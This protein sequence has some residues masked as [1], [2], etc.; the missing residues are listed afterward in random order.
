MRHCWWKEVSFT[1]FYPLWNTSLIFTLRRWILTNTLLSLLF[2]LF[3]IFKT[4]SSN[5]CCK[6]FCNKL[7]EPG[8]DPGFLN[9]GLM[10]D[11]NR[12][13]NYTLLILSCCTFVPKHA[14]LGRTMV[15]WLHEVFASHVFPFVSPSIYFLVDCSKNGWLAIQS[16]PPGSK[17]WHM[18]Y[19]LLLMSGENKAWKQL[20]THRAP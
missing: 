12:P 8:A 18:Y 3:R 17:H 1:V 16:T 2:Y 6:R 7:K 5:S 15:G 10:I 9:G 4:W 20:Q 19:Q 13:S 11:T 14:D